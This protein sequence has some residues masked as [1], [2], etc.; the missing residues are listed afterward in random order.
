MIANMKRFKLSAFFLTTLL[1]VI[2]DKT[3]GQEINGDTI[4]VDSKTVVAVRFPSLPSN[5]YTNPPD[6]SYNFIS[7]PTGFT[8][9]ARKKNTAQATLTV[10][11][12]KRTHNFIIVYK[13][14]VDNGIAKVAD[15]DFST[16]K[17]LKERVKQ[18]EERQKKYD[19]AIKAADKSYQD[20]DFEN[21]KI[22]YEQALVFLNKAYPKEQLLKIKK[23]LKKK[24]RRN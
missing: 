23:Q 17:K 8:I 6:A 13:K 19:D 5:F 21:A 1:L 15:Y 4:Y 11:E 10:I 12:N 24:K 9:I 20:E 7:L 22:S 16:T 2:T 18:L 3:I 14:P